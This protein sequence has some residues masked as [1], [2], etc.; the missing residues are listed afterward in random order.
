MGIFAYF[1]YMALKT[2]ILNCLAAPITFI[3]N[4]ALRFMS[5]VSKIRSTRG[6]P[7]EMA[8]G[9]VRKARTR[10]IDLGGTP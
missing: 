7:Q 5:D 6:I 2:E 8:C 4:L 10:V 9:L 3:P 1:S